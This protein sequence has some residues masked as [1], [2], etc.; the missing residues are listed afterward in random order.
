MMPANAILLSAGFGTRMGPLTA[1]RP[2]PL[3]PV[4]GRPLI[5]HGLNLLTEA[6]VRRVV[7]NLHY[8]GVMI[9]QHLAGRAAPEIVFS[10]EMPDLLDTGGGIAQ[11]LP[12]LGPDPF[13]A[14]NSDSIWTGPN[15]M[16]VLAQGWTAEADA[17]LLLVARDHAR[18][19]TRA[20]DFLLERGI[21]ARR[22]SA[23]SAPYVYTGAQIVSPAAFAGIAPGIFSMNVIW[24][25]L[26]AAGRL[27]AVVHDG[28]WVDVGTPEGLAAASAALG[29]A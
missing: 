8:R 23:A 26:L 25:R 15:P 4:A 18:A 9:R 21:P 3:L 7:I 19:Y 29:E 2:K 5:D 10:E 11:A 17:L 27:R 14:V 16:A 12:L 20:G 28:G 1:D 24:D 22:G 13:F 6:G